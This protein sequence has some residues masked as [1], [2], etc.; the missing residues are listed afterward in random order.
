MPLKNR[1]LC[2]SEHIILA[3]TSDQTQDFAFF[4]ASKQ[5]AYS[6][7]NYDVLDNIHHEAA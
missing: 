4:S 6:I 5:L 2:A 1:C 7:N 3:G